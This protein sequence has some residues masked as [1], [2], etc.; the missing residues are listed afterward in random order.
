MFL[1]T[2]NITKK[3]KSLSTFPEEDEENI[4]VVHEKLE[5]ILKKDEMCILG[6]N[7]SQNQMYVFNYDQF[8]K[9]FSDTFNIKPYENR[10]S[11][12]KGDRISETEEIIFK[13]DF[14]TIIIKRLKT[15]RL[16]SVKEDGETKVSISTHLVD[17]CISVIDNNSLKEEKIDIF[18]LFDY[19]PKN[20]G[21]HDLL[22]SVDQT[23]QNE[24]D[25]AHRNK[26]P[27]DVYLDRVDKKFQDSYKIAE[28][29]I[30]MNEKQMKNEW[31]K[32]HKGRKKSYVI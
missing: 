19:Y 21:L 2:R 29:K 6:T 22:D 16:F 3:L 30:E 28:Y 12:K 4:P 24:W 32:M 8:L 15:P 7:E 20:L 26:K 31:I 11:S 17:K 1:K 10:I 27:G 5:Q 13:D 14:N 18:H 25:A 23:I 9:V